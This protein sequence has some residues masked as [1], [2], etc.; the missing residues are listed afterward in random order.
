MITDILIYRSK[1][2]WL[3]GLEFAILFV[4]LLLAFHA[5]EDLTY[6]H[7]NIGRTS[8]IRTSISRINAIAMSVEGE[9]YGYLLTRD[10]SYVT[11]Y[12]ASLEEVTK[13]LNT[14]KEIVPTNSNILQ[15]SIELEKLTGEILETANTIMMADNKLAL[16]LIKAGTA[17]NITQSIRM[18]VRQL[19]DE[20]LKL[21]IIRQQDIASSRREVL[22]I[23]PTAVVLNI[24]LLT[25][26]YI[27]VLSREDAEKSDA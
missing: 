23:L 24:F 2:R 13:N 7:E 25:Y 4:S 15:L 1:L 16:E 6:A 10:P 21:V 19:Q 3:F 12:D 14:L 18:K 5:I 26:T 20:E 9:V 27:L 22:I 8:I 17:R 11:T